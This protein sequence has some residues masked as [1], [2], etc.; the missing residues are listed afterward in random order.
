MDSE[1]DRV[2]MLEE[3]QDAKFAASTLPTRDAVWNTLT[4]MSKD[5]GWDG[6]CR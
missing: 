2:R 1:E 3:F 4:Q 6:H 5:G